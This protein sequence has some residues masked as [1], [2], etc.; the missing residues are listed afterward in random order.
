MS[1]MPEIKWESPAPKLG[2]RGWR[3]PYVAVLKENPGEWALM[4]EHAKS[5]TNLSLWKRLGCEATSRSNGDDTFR[6]Y[7]RWPEQ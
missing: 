4:E 7:A 1:N 2:E 6:I 3:T 5:A